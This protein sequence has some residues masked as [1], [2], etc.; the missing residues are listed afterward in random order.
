MKFETKDL[1]QPKRVCYR[2]KEAREKSG[3]SL[4]FVCK[5]MKMS[6]K[7]VEALEECRFDDI[8]FADIYRKN[9][10]RN[11]CKTLGLPAQQYLDQYES[12]EIAPDE[13]QTSNYEQKYSKQRIINVPS[14][15]KTGI[16]A[17]VALLILGYIGFEVR[18][19]L[20]PPKLF[21]TTPIEGDIVYSSPVQV[22]GFT[23]KE[24]RVFLNGQEIQT[25]IEGNFFHEVD[26]KE[27]LNT[28]IVGAEKK[29]G[30][31][32]S[33]TRH[34]TFRIPLIEIPEEV[35]VE[36]TTSTPT[37]ATST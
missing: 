1:E 31:S 12:E 33:L 6:K 11:Y 21:L 25:D 8:P 7:W 35:E 22:K 27:G 18:N 24:A 30:K 2:L 23:E 14:I 32:N 34:I 9:L 19:I 5:K 13:T 16:V 28:I 37:T 26:L 36:I 4:D 10:I 3:L 29:H 15:V 20:R 17:F